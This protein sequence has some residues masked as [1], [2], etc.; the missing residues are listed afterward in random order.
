HSIPDKTY[1]NHL[2]RVSQ[3]Q[4]IFGANYFIEYLKNTQCFIFWDKTIHGNSYAD[5]EL[6][7]TS[8]K[9][10]ARYYRKNI[11]QIEKEGERQH[12]T[13]KSI[14]IYKWLLKNYA[15]EGDKIIDTH[16]GSMS[17]A[18]ACHD[19][20]YDLDLWEL[21][22]DYFAAGKKR[23]DNHIKQLQLW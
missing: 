15:K 22:S 13:Q 18:L 4:I 9:S 17:I 12:P 14:H 5:G 8:F 20:K 10:P 3:N 19:M 21:D 7:W 6:L 11:A 1:F 2:F 23:Y 16:G